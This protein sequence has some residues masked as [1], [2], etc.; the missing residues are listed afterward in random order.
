MEPRRPSVCLSHSLLYRLLLPG[1]WSRV[2]ACPGLRVEV[3]VTWTMLPPGSGGSGTRAVF[4][5]TSSTCGQLLLYRLLLM[6]GGQRGLP[7]PRHGW[8]VAQVSAVG[9][10][11]NG[12]PNQ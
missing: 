1:G 2:V 10:C 9:M 7:H 8:C 4:R 11:A 3:H 5:V 6:G 12:R